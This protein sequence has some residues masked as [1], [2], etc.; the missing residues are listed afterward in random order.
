MLGS[1][2][3]E[4][5]QGP[6][7][8]AARKRRS[9]LAAL[10]LEPGATMT[11]DRLVDLVWG[12]DA[13]P[14][15]HGTMHTYISGLRRSLEP[16]LAP[17]ARPTVLVT[18]DAGYRL[19]VDRT[20]VDAAWFAAEVRRLHR[21]LSPLTTQLTTGPDPAWPSRDEVLTHVEALEEALRAWRGTAYADLPDHPDVLAERAALDELRATAEEDSALGLLALGEHAGVVAA[22][23][24]ATARST[25]RE[26]PW[27]LHALALARS[28]RQAEALEAIRTVRGLLADELGLD[29]GPE[30]RG[31]ESAILRQDPV[32]S[33]WL[34]PVAAE[35]SDPVVPD[36]VPPGA[37]VGP[38]PRAAG[39]TPTAP[40]SLGSLVPGAASTRG[41]APVHTSWATVGREPERAALAGVLDRAVAGTPSFAEIVGEPGIGKTRLVDDLVARALDRDVAA[42]VGRCS[43]DDGAPPLW[44]WLALLDGLAGDAADGP[45]ATPGR[46]AVT[47]A[48]AFLRPADGD[49][50]ADSA[51]R[52]FAVRESLAGAVRRRALEGPVLLVVE[53]LHWADTLTLR[54]L[55]HLVATAASGE[56][57]AVV[58][59]RRPWPRPSGALADLGVALARHG[60]VH[61]EPAG[62][63]ATEAHRLVADVVDL[64][65]PTAVGDGG[66]LDGSLVTRTGGNPFFLVE[67]ARFAGS[68]GAS[69]G[70]LPASVQ[71]VVARRLDDLPATTRELLLVSAALGRAHAPLLLSVVTGEDASAIDEGLEPAHAVGL[72]RHRDDGMLAFDHALTRD[73]VLAAEPVS[74][75]ARVHAQIARALESSAPGVI[76]PQERAFDLARH[77]LAAGPVHAPQAWRSAAAAADLAQR[78][79]ADAEATDLLRAAEAAHRLDPAGTREERYGLLLEL[80]AVASRSALWRNVVDSVVEAAALARADDDPER[81]A[82]AVFELTRHSVWLPQEMGEVL[83]DLVDDVRWAL[84]GVGEH[85]SRTRCVLMTAL[86]CQLYYLPGAEPEIDALVDEGWAMARRLG[87]PEL[88]GWAARTGFLA[89]WRSHQLD[90]RRELAEEEV[91]AGRERDDPVAVALGLTI[92]G[93]VAVE[94]GDLATW[95]AAADEAEAL[96][97]PRRL[98]YVTFVLD[99]VR[100]NLA[101][102]RGDAA[103]AETIAGQV[104][105]TRGQVATPAAAFLDFG[106]AYVENIWRP[107]ALEA[108]VDPMV[109]FMHAQDEQLLMAQDVIVQVLARSRRV[110]LLRRSSTTGSSARSATSG[111]PRRWR[112]AAPRPRRCSATPRWRTTRR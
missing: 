31:L 94:A 26:R 106:I 11:P 68:G 103:A 111:T 18:T 109:E 56:R 20:D 13:P 52:A 84:A 51:E 38:E 104:R 61:L 88:R 80:A 78:S 39:G 53:D 50:D 77:W 79:F 93:G 82:R 23:E 34:R 101:L 92:L 91:A 4:G 16:D 19:A 12:G 65:L 30:L 57:L 85:D 32:L 9:I 98:A 86:A 40:P 58:V 63:S 89:L 15:A 3:F 45:D 48:R 41:P 42:V 62:L 60:G 96:A 66:L 108:A 24:Q 1:T 21:A 44:P 5:P 8:L 35:T 110:D 22:T 17:R 81:V 47:E 37:A 71:Q 107:E 73:A 75:V 90:M 7:E 49:D 27:A 25:L 102:L 28:G 100:L 43:Q 97:R 99:F 2:A 72:V 33:T 74:R 10:A 64:G 6:V 112:R 67:L 59:T 70:E 46:A 14:G 55:T 54:A 87:D 95:T 83:V 69:G 105:E 29:P 76:G 36:A